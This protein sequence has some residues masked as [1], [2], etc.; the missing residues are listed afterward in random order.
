MMPKEFAR[1]LQAALIGT[2]AYV[3]PTPA[4]KDDL[5]FFIKQG[6]VRNDAQ[7]VPLWKGYAYALTPKGLARF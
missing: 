6:W 3:A 4:A 5:A 1:I 2:F 7:P